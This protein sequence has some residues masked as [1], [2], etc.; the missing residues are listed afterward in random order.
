MAEGLKKNVNVHASHPVHSLATIWL[1]S[2]RAASNSTALLAMPCREL[3]T[4]VKLM[5]RG[6]VLV[7]Q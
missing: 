6:D 7:G 1:Y 2:L 3:H 5:P 4:D